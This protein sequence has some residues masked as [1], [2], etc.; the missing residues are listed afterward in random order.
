M[1]GRSRVFMSKT[2]KRSYVAPNRLKISSE[3]V[4][5]PIYDLSRSTVIARQ[6][7]EARYFGVAMNADGWSSNPQR[8]P[9]LGCMCETPSVVRTAGAVDTYS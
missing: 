3:S 1:G 6:T 5:M 2:D 4:M 7:S 8:R 9:M